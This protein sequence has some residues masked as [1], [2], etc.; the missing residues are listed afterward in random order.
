[1]SSKENREWE[2]GAEKMSLRA[3]MS[4]KRVKSFAQ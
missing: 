4:V 2:G 1:M 3:R